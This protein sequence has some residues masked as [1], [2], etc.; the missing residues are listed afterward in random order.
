MP[1]RG[2]RST[3][4]GE[5]RPV[6]LTEVLVALDPQPG[7]VAVDCTTGFGGHAAELLRHVGPTGRLIALDLDPANLPRAEARL[8]E[9]GHPFSLHHLNFA[10]VQQAL[11]AAG[12][13]RADVVLADLGVSS[14]QIDDAGRGFSFMRD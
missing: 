14:M 3:Q 6:L 11:A 5:H 9:V 10:G 12:V 8:A 13:E 2:P 7:Q 4:A 1:G